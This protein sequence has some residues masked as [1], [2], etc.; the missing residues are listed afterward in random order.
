AGY[1]RQFQTTD[2]SNEAF[3][4]SLAADFPG[5]R[6]T[7]VTF[8]DLSDLEAPVNIAYTFTGA[9][10]LQGTDPFRF[11]PTLREANLAP[12]LASR[13]S[14]TQDLILGHP[15]Q[16]NER[17]TIKLPPGYKAKLP[18]PIDLQSPFGRFELQARQ[19][20]QT[21]TIA[22]TLAMTTHRIAATDYAAFRRW[23]ESIDAALATP[24]TAQP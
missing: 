16:D 23:L 4:R 11:L 9:K 19:E 2:S 21:V 12:R 22:M 10:L 17:Y 24:I 8:S 18:P 15:Y 13:T 7:E 5:A 3:G 6:A 14:R 20:G 1:R